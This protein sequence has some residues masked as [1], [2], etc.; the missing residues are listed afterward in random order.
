MCH[1][2]YST[3]IYLYY[4][5][6]EVIRVKIRILLDKQSEHKLIG[7]FHSFYYTIRIDTFANLEKIKPTYFQ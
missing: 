2:L 1:V 5:S 4:F 3:C 6:L 7:I